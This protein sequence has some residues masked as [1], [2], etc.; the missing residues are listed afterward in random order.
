MQKQLLPEAEGYA[1]NN[2]RRLLW[3]RFVRVM[4]C[5]VVFCTTY[6]LILPA[7]TME[8]NSV[9]EME[10]HTHSESCYNQLTSLETT[11]LVCT[12]ES[13]QIHRHTESCYG[14][15]G[16]PI[17]GLADFVVHTHNGACYDAE[18]TL[19][20][21]LPVI[22]LHEHTEVCY[23]QEEPAEEAQHEHDESCYTTQQGELL[24]QVDTEQAHV[25]G[26]AC[27]SLQT[28]SCGLVESEGHTHTEE[29]KQTVLVCDQTEEAH[30]HED[31]CYQTDLVCGMTEEPGHIHGETCY[32]Q[33]Y[34]CGM[35]EGAVHIHGD[36][37]YAVE[38]VL[39]CQIEQEAEESTEPAGETTEPTEPVLICE[40]TEIIL[41]IHSD[42]CY[43]IT[44]DAAG[45]ECRTLTC[46]KLEIRQHSHGD[47]CFVTETVS[48]DTENL[49]CGLEECHVHGDGCYDEGGGLI[50]TEPTLGHVHTA[51]CYGTWTLICE[52]E[53]HTHTED[54]EP[55]P[56]EETE[57]LASE[58]CLNTLSYMG[59]DY[60]VIL[61]FDE[62]ACIPAN[63]ELVV[64]ELAGEEYQ[65]YLEQ[66]YQAI[67]DDSSRVVVRFSGEEAPSGNATAI[68]G[69]ISFA[70][71][72]DLTILA[73][74]EEIEP[75]DT[76]E[77]TIRYDADVTIP[78]G[79]KTAVHFTNEGDVETIS[80]EDSI[81]MAVRNSNTYSVQSETTRYKGE[82]FVFFQD[83][84]S[85]TGTITLG[86][87]SI[88]YDNITEMDWFCGNTAIK[89]LTVY[90]NFGPGEEKSILIK[91]P[92]GFRIVSYSATE[93]TPAISE[94]TKVQIDNEFKDYVLSSELMPAS[95]E[96]SR[97][98][99][100]THTGTWESQALSGYTGYRSNVEQDYRTH[101]GDIKYTLSPNTQTVR[102]VVSLHIDQKLLSHTS[103]TED[104]DP[105]E[106]IIKSDAEEHKSCISV[107]A[108]DI[109]IASISPLSSDA[110]GSDH[111]NAPE[112]GEKPGYSGILP[113]RTVFFN[114]LHAS[115]E[116]ESYFEKLQFCLTYPKGVFLEPDSVFFEALGFGPDNRIPTLV[117]DVD[118]EVVEN[119]LWVKW[120][121]DEDGGGTITWSAQNGYYCHT[122]STGAIGADFRANTDASRGTFYRGGDSIS[123]FTM[124]LTMLERNGKVGAYKKV[125]YV[126]TLIP[127]GD[128]KDI[129]L[130]PLNLTRRDIT[131]DFKTDAYDYALGGYNVYSA[132]PYTDNTFYFENVH[133]LKITALNLMGQNARNIVVVTNKKTIVLDEWEEKP[134]PIPGDYVRYGDIHHGN[135]LKLS[136]IGGEDGEYIK[137]C[138]FTADFEQVTYQATQPFGAFV[139]IGQ[140]QD[141]DGD[142]SR[143]GDVILRQLHDNTTYD[144]V[145]EAIENGTLDALTM[146]NGGYDEAYGQQPIV[147]TDH[148]TIG[149]TNTGVGAVKTS[150]MNAETNKEQSTYYAN[151]RLRFETVIESGYKMKIFDK[152]NNQ[153]ML[154][155]PVLVISL[156]KGLS[157]DT[158]SVTAYAAAGT[159]GGEPVQLVQAGIAR[160]TDINGVCWRTYR[161]QVPEDQRLALVA[162]EM[163]LNSQPQSPQRI[164]AS[165]D[166]VV[167]PVCGQYDLSLQ[168]IIM[169]DVRNTAYEEDT[170]TTVTQSGVNGDAVASHWSAT[171]TRTDKNN[172]LGHGTSYGVANNGGTIVI[173]PLIGLNVDLGIKPVA[174]EDDP[175]TDSGFT[176][177]NGLLSS[178]APVIP[179]KYADVQLS[180]LSTSDN[181]YFENTVIYIPIPKKGLDY[182][183]Y[184]ENVNLTDP[185]NNETAA[186]TKTFGFTMDLTGPVEL[187]N[188][189]TVWDTYYAV[190]PVSTNPNPHEIVTPD[191]EG[192][193][194]I[195]TWE[196][197][198]QNGIEVDWVT[199]E[200][201]DSW[202]EVVMLKFVAKDN[203]SPNET[204][205]TVMRLYVHDLD[206]DGP[207]LG[208]TYNYW[209]GYGKAVTHAASQIGNWKYTSVVAATPAMET[210]VGQIFVDKDRDGLF[211]DTEL[212]YIPG[213]YTAELS[214]VGGGMD[215]RVLVVNE[216]GS[217]A[218]VD[219][220]GKPEY[221]P[222]GSYT[223]TIRRNSDPNFLF[224]NTNYN[225]SI[226]MESPESEWHNNVSGNTVASWQFEV[227]NTTTEGIVVHRI[228]V[229]LKAHVNI[230]LRGSKTLYGSKMKAGDYS[231]SLQAVNNAPVN[232]NS[233]KVTAD[234]D[235]AF[236]TILYEQPG[237]YQY[238]ITEDCANPHPGILYDYHT[239]TVTVEVTEDSTT[240]ILTATVSYDNSTAKTDKD[241]AVT[242]WAAFTND[243]GYELP[244][245][246][247]AGTYLHAMG[248]LLLM[249]AAAVL[250]HT[251]NLKRRKEERPSF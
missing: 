22:R 27:G 208:G 237:T 132:L 77:V 184:F 40:E 102:L 205:S 1:R 186:N 64:V 116:R 159:S 182:T 236:G 198:V 24:C 251:H 141:G 222:A 47:D 30:V 71:F 158:S 128:Q 61:R 241:R 212:N 7:I 231:F 120:Q 5:I 8:K 247:G 154:I 78:E 15:D 109:P 206:K 57:P 25:H 228:G 76:V 111:Y 248:G 243:V 123:D 81:S 146:T 140:F 122:G 26:E 34:A 142:G 62:A 138:L 149:W 42:A 166:V 153:D 59:D 232:G 112:K 176:T 80:A 29:C 9:C 201:V 103:S 60:E 99:G 89:T 96:G 197:V 221:L 93:D 227:T 217:F 31:S 156:P 161:F 118:M 136:Q 11:A 35:E 98:V 183:K 157:L 224:A 210:L 28:L 6:A 20:C 75:K 187:S 230:T 94:V 100:V 121:E 92:T 129:R 66:T 101:G 50:C 51:M 137:A 67:G 195:D 168:D 105:I 244:Q 135:L 238:K 174:N 145:Q 46:E 107:T 160:E 95:T 36:S 152:L 43:K 58:E 144:A 45:N 52:L 175:F 147:A 65:Y 3:R 179:D 104:M 124:E 83:S 172:F 229:G 13:L 215:T 162:T 117:K 88:A 214:K 37:C 190:K 204:G 233:A 106:V 199:A 194:I 108:T 85:V 240:G 235:F 115:N 53:E 54:C 114:Y 167:D 70:R 38:E 10:E 56:I 193:G 203:V 41:H 185:M 165:F 131:A 73:E 79:Q 188:S 97:I 72:F 21:P 12:R 250:L 150:V 169:W 163:L 200:K 87:D 143:E 202:N 68:S 48:V 74:G 220:N 173:K 164:S 192:E 86:K 181:D 4:V 44:Q 191:Q 39:T 110:T 82:S 32:T 84:F 219:S 133:D 189:Q 126:R 216:D 242:D 148:T 63:A 16:Q 139:Y 17:C 225:S 119:H 90:A 171:C 23:L 209:R 155:D 180:Y 130:I 239:T 113:I 177:Y 226:G 245:T 234:G 211:D 49:T 151:D 18:G 33:T 125:N 127:V 246:G 213:K 218:L 223:V 2:V 134:G 196:P 14:A 178:V 55:G 91:V 207:A 19:V 249:M 69:A 170:L